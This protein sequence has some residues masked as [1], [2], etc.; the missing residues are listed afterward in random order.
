[1][2]VAKHLKGDWRH[3]IDTCRNPKTDQ[4]PRK[5]QLAEKHP[6]YV[7]DTKDAVRLCCISLLR[8]SEQI[9]GRVISLDKKREFSSTYLKTCLTEP[10]V[11]WITS[12]NTARL[13]AYGNQ[14]VPSG[15]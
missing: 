9:E 15:I 2:M 1:M 6:P 8:S 14:L 13:L 3:T 12:Q 4:V 10:L 7:K 11:S 5:K